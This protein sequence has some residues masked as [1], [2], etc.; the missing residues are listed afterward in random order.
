MPNIPFACDKMGIVSGLQ[1]NLG[2]DQTKPIAVLNIYKE[3][4]TMH[5]THSTLSSLVDRA[6]MGNQ[7]P[8]E[9]YLREQSRL[10]G[11][12]ANLE[13]VNEMSYL[14]AALSSEQ[15]EKVQT[16]LNYLISDDRK[17]IVSNTPAEFVV[18]CGIVAY[19]ACAAVHSVWRSEVY[20]LLDQFACSPC[21]RV[22]QGV[23]IAFQRL[24]IAT[25]QDTISYLTILATQGNYLQQRAAVAA[26]AEPALLFSPELVHAALSLQFVVLERV[27][28]SSAL[29]RKREDFRVL[30]QTLG[31]AI[32]VVAAVTP[33][34]GF[35]LMRTCASWGDTDITWIL[36]ENLKKKRLAKFVDYTEVLA[37]LLA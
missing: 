8:L 20:E 34:R 23:E 3:H 16:L 29:D 35:A 22:R 5:S 24:L 2:K 18:L 26:I 11:P 15:P 14:L 32:S 4:V 19:G 17:K 10:P 31:Y 12:R 6:L 13:L 37:K 28:A 33:E 30:R 7:R 1:G 27:H 9:F 36:R 25:P 21:W